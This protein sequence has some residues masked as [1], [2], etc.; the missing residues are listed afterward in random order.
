MSD[1]QIDG[2][3]NDRRELGDG[4]N[5]LSNGG[6]D[7]FTAVA[8]LVYS[9]TGRCPDEKPYSE[10][11]FPRPMPGCPGNGLAMFASFTPSETEPLGK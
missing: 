4:A 8:I 11:P 5:R 9:I 10:L 7:R 2:H 3:N 1:A 6:G